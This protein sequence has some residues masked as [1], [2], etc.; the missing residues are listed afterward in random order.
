M[1]A[2]QTTRRSGNIASFEASLNGGQG[3]IVLRCAPDVSA[4]RALTP[5]QW[6]LS[7]TP[8]A[9]KAHHLA[10]L[11]GGQ[12]VCRTSISPDSMRCLTVS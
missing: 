6:V 2:E 12:G 4:L 10:S 1:N 5:N 7:R 3:G 8:F 9:K 11:F